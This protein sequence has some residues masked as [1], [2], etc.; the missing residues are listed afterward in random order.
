MAAVFLVLLLGRD[1]V[2]YSATVGTVTV[3]LYLLAATLIAG[4][5]WLASRA[6]EGAGGTARVAG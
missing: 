4:A 1:L 2:V 3:G 5:L 6:V